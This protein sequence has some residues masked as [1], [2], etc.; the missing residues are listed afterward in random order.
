LKWQLVIAPKVQETL[1]TLP[2]QTKRY[3]RQAFLAIVQDPRGSK[4]LRAEFSGFYSFRVKRFRVVYK[5]QEPL[6]I[7]RVVGLGP[8][9]TIYEDLAR[10]VSY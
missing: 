7:I 4:P 9:K 10:E 8:R 5:I 6:N 2:P 3:V 1:R